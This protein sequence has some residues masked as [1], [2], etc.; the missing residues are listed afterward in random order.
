M[1]SRIHCCSAS[2]ETSPVALS[3]AN[4]NESEEGDEVRV[5]HIFIVDRTVP[6]RWKIDAAQGKAGRIMVTETAVSYRGYHRIDQC[7]R[8]REYH[9]F[10]D[11]KFKLSTNIIRQVCISS[12]PR[13]Y[14]LQA[15]SSSRPS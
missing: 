6:V 10:K 1:D 12:G 5:S 8:L 14:N 9:R 3:V 7:R 4:L 15:W 2:E 11:F 13:L